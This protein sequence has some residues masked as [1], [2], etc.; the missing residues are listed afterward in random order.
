MM[1]IRKDSRRNASLT[2]FAL[3]QYCNQ[4]YLGG[5][6]VECGGDGVPTKVGTSGGD[7]GNCYHYDGAQ[8]CGGFQFTRNVAYCCSRL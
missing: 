7:F 6:S 1:L 5:S 2:L 3:R 4:P 8:S